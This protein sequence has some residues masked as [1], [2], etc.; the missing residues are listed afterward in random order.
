MGKIRWTALLLALVLALTALPAP[1]AGTEE[2]GTEAYS[3]TDPYGG[4]APWDSGMNHR[5][6]R[7]AGEG[8]NGGLAPSSFEGSGQPTRPAGEGDYDGLAPAE[9]G[10]SQNATRPAGDGDYGG[11]APK[12]SSASQATRPA[13]AGDNGGVAPSGKTPGQASRPAGD[14]DYGGLAPSAFEEP[15]QPSRPAGD[16]DY[17]GLAPA[18]TTPAKKKQ[19]ASLLAKIE[20]QIIAGVS[21]ST[22]SHNAYVYGSGGA[23]ASFHPARPVTRAE[24]AQML[25]RLLPPDQPTGDGMAFTDVPESA[26]Y[27]GA[28]KTLAAL[29]VLEANSKKEL[30]PGQELTRG[31]FTRYV[32]CFFPLRTDAELFA[33]VSEE[34]PNA[35]FIRSA[36]A[37]GWAMGGKDGTFHPDE[38][39]N[40]AAAVVLLNRALGRTPDITYIQRNHPT[41]YIDVSPTSWYYYDV[42]EATVSHQHTVSDGETWLSHSPKAEVPKDGMQLVDG[43]LFRY[44]SARGDVVRSDKVGNFTF[45]A[46]GHFT[47]GNAEL[48]DWLHRIVLVRTDSSMTQEQMLRVLYVYTRDSFTYLRR[49]PYEF[50]VYDYMETDALR[51]LNT[52]YGNC[53]CYASLFWYLSRWIGYDSVIYNGTVGV[54]RSPHSWVE[55]NMNGKDYIF[56]TELEMAYRRKKRFDVNLYKFYDAGNS[57]NYRRPKS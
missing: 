37:W 25:C 4:L 57:W 27:A 54:R 28:V 26:W 40:R 36:R 13:G 30:N 16:G 45:D 12:D 10:D 2:P 55:I 17:G 34:D 50:G 19:D 9:K 1:A 21:L 46:E 5:P 8:D 20:G 23:F 56:D 48:D 47:T 53:Y 42:M 41:F 3:Q 11:L 38:T 43:W 39:I 14:G 32:A 18:Q 33:D 31:E 52:G 49:A 22:T 6:T 24:A 15:N 29:G 7:P 51:I 44:D 35:P